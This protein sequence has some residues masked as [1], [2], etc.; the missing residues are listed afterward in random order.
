MIKIIIGTAV[1]LSILG[2]GAFY[3]I[4]TQEQPNVAQDNPRITEGAFVPSIEDISGTGSFRGLL[5][6]GQ[7]VACTVSYDTEEQGTFQGD[8][9]VADAKMRGDFTYTMDGEQL[10]ISVINDGAYGYTWGNTPV[11]DLAMKYALDENASEDAAQNTAFDYDQR[12][13]YSCAPW[14]TD[15]SFFIP[16]SDIIFSEMNMQQSAV[17]QAGDLDDVKTAQCNACA[18]ITDAS[19]K[20]QCLVALSCN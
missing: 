1:A 14:K 20:E 15:P 12:V 17:I 8:V 5:G 11:G 4:S 6:L 16:P 7:N 13:S 9:Y 18:M 19:S 3:Y 2:A 10:N